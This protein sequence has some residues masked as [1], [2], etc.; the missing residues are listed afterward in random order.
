M[1]CVVGNC[2]LKIKNK[3]WTASINNYRRHL[4]QIHKVKPKNRINWCSLCHIDIGRQ[5]ATHA[6]FVERPFFIVSTEKMSHKCDYPGCKE[7]Y[8]TW[9]AL[10]GHRRFHK[11][12]GIQDEYNRRNGLPVTGPSLSPGCSGAED[13]E[14]DIDKKLA[15]F[16]VEID[17]SDIDQLIGIVSEEEGSRNRIEDTGGVTPEFLAFTSGFNSTHNSSMSVSITHG[18][19]HSSEVS[20]VHVFNESNAFISNLAVHDSRASQDT[21]PA[22]CYGN[23]SPRPLSDNGI[24]GGVAAREE[25]SLTCAVEVDIE[26]SA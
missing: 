10:S 17:D 4:E 20:G 15:E 19:C 26:S 21:L 1:A 16:G 13:E 23:S 12:Q 9:R 11:T 24:D 22:G 18:V 6:C 3:T 7:T 2:K 8:P 25:M 5:V 14:G